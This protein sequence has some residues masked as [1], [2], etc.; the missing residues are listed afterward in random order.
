MAVSELLSNQ[1]PRGLY[2]RAIVCNW[3][4]PV[5]VL[6]N[7]LVARA[8]TKYG[9]E[10]EARDVAR[11]MLS[12]MVKDIRETGVLHENYNAE[13]GQGLWAPRFMSW[14]LLALELIDLVERTGQKRRHGGDKNP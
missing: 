11:R 12:A 14:N 7:V 10:N 5:W 13:T 3:N 6:V 8:L 9:L 4:G 1:A 2:G